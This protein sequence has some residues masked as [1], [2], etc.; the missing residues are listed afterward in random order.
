MDNEQ[1]LD[2]ACRCFE[3]GAYDE[4]LEAFILAYCKGYERE[5][6]LDNIYACYMNGNEPEFRV[7]YEQSGESAQCAYED[8]VIDFVPYKE[9]AYYM[10]DKSI[11]EFRGVFS[12]A[13][14]EQTEP[15]ENLKQM[16]FSAVALEMDW[17]WTQMKHILT[18]AKSRKI[19]AVCHDLARAM[20]FWKVPELAEYLKNVKIFADKNS[21]Q[22]YFH[23]NTSVYLPHIIYGND[24]DMQE[25]ARIIEQEHQYRLTPEGRDADNVLLTIAIPTYNRGHLL[26]ER[27]KN[28]M[29]MLYDAEV[30]IVI[31]RHGEQY[32]AEYAQAAQ[33]LDARFKYDDYHGTYARYTLNWIHAVEMAS[34][35]YVMLVSDEDDV[36]IDAL[37]HYLKLLST[38][39]NLNLLRPQTSFQYCHVNQRQY[40]RRGIDAFKKAF[41]G[42]NYISGMTFDRVALLQNDLYELEK[43]QIDNV[44]YRNYPHEWWCASVVRTGDYIEEPVFLIWENDSIAALEAEYGKKQQMQNGSN[45]QPKKLPSYATYEARLDLMRGQVDFVHWYMGN[46]KQGAFVGMAAVICKISYLMEMAREYHYKPDNFPEYVDQFI[47]ESMKAIDE[48][49]FT[50]GMKA[51]LLESIKQNALSML[52]LDQEMK[53]K[54]NEVSD[55]ETF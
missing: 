28:S 11:G 23:R 29:Q 41:L 39:E 22:Q 21:L 3:S 8:C 44:F 17:D 20:S 55:N 32:D 31:S 10:F 50:E 49:D 2:H 18:D 37:E 46:D 15:D 51:G 24:R 1:I 13:E 34:G 36:I 42:Q 40:G 52:E 45:A 26:L 4:A 54:E 35:K 43:T 5:W 6:V 7:A 48:F 30:E 47:W 25:Y 14:L 38:T 33:M 9:G 16:E 53:K 12:M 27:I 19:Y